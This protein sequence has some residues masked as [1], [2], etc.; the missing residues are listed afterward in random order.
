MKALIIQ[1]FGRSTFAPPDQA[2]PFWAAERDNSV[3][4]LIAC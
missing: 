4:I 2:L 1:S 3:K